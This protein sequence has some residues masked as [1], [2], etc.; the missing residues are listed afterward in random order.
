M[1]L[2]KLQCTKRCCE[3][4]YQLSNFKQPEVSCCRLPSVSFPTYHVFRHYA[5][6]NLTSKGFSSSKISIKDKRL[7]IVRTSSTKSNDVATIEKVYERFYEDGGVQ[8]LVTKENDMYHVDIQVEGSDWVLH[9]GIDGWKAPDSCHWP[10]GTVQVDDKAVRTPFPS[11]GGSLRISFHEERLPSKIVFVLNSGDVWMNAGGQD[12]LVVLRT[13]DVRDLEKRILEAES[14]YERW[15]LFNRL[16]MASQVIDEAVAIGPEAMALVF[17]WLRLS[18][19]RQL[20]WYRGSNY[21]SKDAAHAQKV[22]ANRIAHAARTAPDPLT[23]FFARECMAVLPRGGGNGDDIRHGIL[24][25]MREYGI[26]EGHR[27]GIDDKFLETWH[28]KL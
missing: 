23:K 11:D 24:N 1:V 2:W 28:Q 25:L 5:R 15:S 6:G 7:D 17:T 22:L 3:R 14:T 9:W 26:R 16:G 13:P 4:A 19:L 18:F 12:Y 20:D 8:T 27:P 21:Q 10:E